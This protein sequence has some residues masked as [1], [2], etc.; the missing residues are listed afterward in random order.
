MIAKSTLTDDA[1]ASAVLHVVG[2]SRAFMLELEG[3]QH[4][5]GS[6]RDERAARL[7]EA[8]ALTLREP[9]RPG[10]LR[11]VEQAASELLRRL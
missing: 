10:A 5:I 9:A 2:R 11:H 7:L 3:A 6:L 1:L 4:E 8:L